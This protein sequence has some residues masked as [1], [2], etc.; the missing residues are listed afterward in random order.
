MR[1]RVSLF[2]DVCP[3]TVSA[4]SYVRQEHVAPP[5]YLFTERCLI[6][7]LLVTQA[8][9]SIELLKQSGIDFDLHERKGV[10]V[11]KF[12]ELIMTSG[13]VLSP[14]IRWI[15]FHSAY[16]FGYLLKVRTRRR[17]DN[18]WFLAFVRVLRRILISP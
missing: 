18:P 14:E 4:S 7:P 15:T 13:V 6:H 2:L 17:S 3:L 12:G 16:D 5:K 10:D 11:R 1:R 8:Q 9:D